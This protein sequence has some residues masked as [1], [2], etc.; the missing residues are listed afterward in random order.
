MNKVP[1]KMMLMLGLG[2]LALM[3]GAKADEWTQ[4]TIVT[5]SEP[6]EIPGQILPAGT[7]VFKLANSS[8]NRNIVQIFNQDENRLFATILAI[9]DYR[10]RASNKPI[11]RFEERTAGS[12]QAIK[13]WFYPH[14]NYGHEFVYP[15]SEALALARANHT[16]VPSMPVE[17]AAETT[18]PANT[19]DSPPVLEFNLAPLRAEEPTGEEVELAEAFAVADVAVPEPSSAL[20]EELPSTATQLPLIALIG[21]LSLGAAVSLRLSSYKLMKGK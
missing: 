7:Y 10:L 20:P 18:K 5:F 6:V 17:L 14:K 8:S 21:L 3:P 1:T 11:I 4:R 19:L 2:V 9:P 15:K 16:P 13:G 12:P